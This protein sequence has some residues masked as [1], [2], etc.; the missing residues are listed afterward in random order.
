MA[1][2]HHIKPLVPPSSNSTPWSVN[3]APPKPGAIAIG[4]SLNY[5]YSTQF[6]V[7]VEIFNSNKIS[8]FIKNEM[9]I[10][11]SIDIFVYIIWL[12]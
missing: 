12:C 4:H 1:T 5:G 7:G 8:G 2:N 10:S 9:T 11:V 6:Y 3:L